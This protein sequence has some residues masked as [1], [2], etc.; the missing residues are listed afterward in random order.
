MALEDPCPHSHG[1][2]W[3]F[4]LPHRLIRSDFVLPA[5]KIVLQNFVPDDFKDEE[6][7]ENESLYAHYY[8]V[9][10][11]SVFSFCKVLVLV[12]V[13]AVYH[14]G[15]DDQ[16][17]R[18]SSEYVLNGEYIFIKVLVHEQR[19]GHLDPKTHADD[20]MANC[21]RPEKAI[22]LVIHKCKKFSD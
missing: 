22:F 15:G 5:L 9:F 7:E 18:G 20:S 6:T 16:S 12:N 13:D 11:V 1:V 2:L 8:E 17:N 14:E 21:E 10:S 4:I 3:N 19:H